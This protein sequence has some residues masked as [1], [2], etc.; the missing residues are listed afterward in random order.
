VAFDVIDKPSLSKIDSI[1]FDLDGTIIDSQQSIIDSLKWS[2]KNAGI[3]PAVNLTRNLIGP[4]LVDTFIKIS[5]HSDERLLGELVDSFKSRYDS[6]GY[7]GGKP[8]LGMETAIRQLHHM[9][10][11]LYIA[12][13]KRLVPTQKIMK[14]FSL[15]GYFKSVYSIDLRMDSPFKNKSEMIE[16]LIADHNIDP[17]H[18]IY[19]GDRIEDH[20]AACANNI[21]CFLVGWGYGAEVGELAGY[22]LVDN[23]K[24]LSV[25]V[26]QLN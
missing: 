11:K 4:P 24:D 18:A 23:P 19:V 1:I 22:S 17:S 8:F 16:G 3:D 9:G 7:R 15:G 26:G 12:T 20:Q 25:R 21:I 5:G 10:Y 14:Y 2:L 6:L 13:N